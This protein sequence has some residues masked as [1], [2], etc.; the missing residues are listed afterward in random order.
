MGRFWDQILHCAAV[1]NY[2]RP[3]CLTQMDLRTAEMIQDEKLPPNLRREAS[4][5]RAEIISAKTFEN[6]KSVW[7][8]QK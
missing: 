8:Y 4:V 7:N 2:V 6:R 3:S 5:I 1:R